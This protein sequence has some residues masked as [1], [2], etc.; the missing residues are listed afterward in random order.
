MTMDDS[1]HPGFTACPLRKLTWI[2]S[3]FI[4]TLQGYE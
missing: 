3:T 2:A 4:L 1:R